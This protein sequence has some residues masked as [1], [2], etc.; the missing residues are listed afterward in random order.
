[1]PL[2]AL[3]D[4]DR[5]TVRIAGIGLS[6]YLVLFGGWKVFGFLGQRH[7]AYRLLQSEAAELRNRHELYGAR[8]T[9]LERLMESFQMDPARLAKTTL[10][11]QAGAALQQSA[12]QGGLQLGPIRETLNRGSERELGIIQMEATG[13]VPAL[14]TFL[15][16]LR[17]LG[18]PFVIDT[19]QFSPDPARPGM[20][21]VSLGLILLDY[22]KWDKKELPDA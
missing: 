22:E 21:K 16:Q 12:T 17:S 8:V 3:T 19:L 1:M 7:A 10:V 4:R 18:F 11:A 2:P 20:L 6:L 14:M 9:R 5:R 13:Q 15:H